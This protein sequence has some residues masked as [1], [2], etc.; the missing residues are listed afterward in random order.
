VHA[1]HA[2]CPLYGDSTYGG[3][4]RVVRTDGSVLGLG[5]VALH[6]AWV[7]LPLGGGVRVESP[8]PD[9][10]LELWSALGGAASG[11]DQALE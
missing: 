10:L 1:A 7:E 2:G 9:P 5:R 6:A 11:W 3:P 8:L 4:K